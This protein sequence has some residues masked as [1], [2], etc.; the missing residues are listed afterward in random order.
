MRRLSVS[1]FIS[2]DGVMQAPGGPAEDPTGHFSLG[3]WNV[4]FWDEVMGAAMAEGFGQPFDL[5]LGRRTYEIFAAHWPYLIDDP[6]ADRLN[7]VTKYVASRTL[8][9]VTW[10]ASRLLEG[11]AGTAVAKLKQ[12][13]GPPL[14]VQG[15]SDLIRT[16][17]RHDL[18][19]EF[20]VWTFPVLLGQGKRLFGEAAP[21]SGLRLV[22]SRTSTTGVLITT[23]E[24]DGDVPLGSFEAEEPSEAEIRRRAGLVE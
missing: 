23:Y 18:I 1:T 10:N 19:D 9:R 11:D 12:Q 17:L 5:L 6:V 7:S 3:G 20:R 14:Q 22:D 2:L 4:T 24:K 21:P 15:S 16:L 8:D 13:E